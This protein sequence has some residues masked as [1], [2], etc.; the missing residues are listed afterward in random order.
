[1]GCVHCLNFKHRRY[2]YIFDARVVPYGIQSYILIENGTKCIST[3]FG[4][5]CTDL[6]TKHIK[7]TAYYPQTNGQVEQY[8]KKIIARQCHYVATRHRNS[9]HFVQSLTCAYDIHAHS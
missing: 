3:Y 5:L 9:D 4:A 7:T 6:G 8:N 2:M 1:M